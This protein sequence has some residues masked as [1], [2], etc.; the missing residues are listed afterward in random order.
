M[1]IGTPSRPLPAL[2]AAAAALLLAVPAAA[3]SGSYGYF[4]VIEGSA[5]VTQAGSGD[6]A[7]AELNQPVL[8]GDRLW[9]HRSGRL[10]AVLSDGNLLRVDG[11]SELLFERLADSPESDDGQ[12]VLRLLQGNVQLVVRR[13]GRELPR[14][15]T[16]NATV[17]LQDEGV[18]RI[19][20]D[21]E[22]WTEVVV[23]DGYAEVVTERGS[24]VVRTD[25][26]AWVEGVRLPD[27]DV[28]AAGSSDALER[29]ARR[30]DDEVEGD[31]YASYV[32]EDLRYQARPLSRYG[33][34]I[35]FNATWVWQPRVAHGWRPYHYGRW[36]YTPAGYFWVTSEPWGW[37]P[38]H[39]GTW[40]YVG[41]H[42]WVWYPGRTFAPAW[43]YW[44]WG[45]NYVGWCPIGY[46]TH[47]YSGWYRNHGFRR[48]VYGWAGGG[49][50]PWNDWSFVPYGHF[51][52]R[53][54]HRHARAGRDLRDTRP[55][56]PGRG[57]LT[58]DTRSLTPDRLGDPRGV[59]EV[60]RRRDVTPRGGDL[61]DV[62]AFVERRDEL[63]PE[64]RRTVITDRRDVPEGSPLRPSVI[65]DR[66][67]G[68]ARGGPEAP[69]VA[70]RDD[71]E[72]GE[73]DA[74]RVVP[75]RPDRPATDAGGETWRVR[76][77]DRSGTGER[78][79]GEGPRV[80]PSRPSRPESEDDGPRA[81]PS[82][83]S[84][85]ESDGGGNESWRIRG[86]D[87]G[88]RGRSESPRV[89]PTDRRPPAED[90]SL[91]YTAPPRR[92]GGSRPSVRSYAMP[93]RPAPSA[94]PPSVRPSRPP[95]SSPPSG[96]SGSYS[97]PPRQ[98]APRAS[99]PPSN[100]GGSRSVAPRSRGSDSPPSRSGGREA[101]GRSRGDGS[102]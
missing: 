71:G 53:D 45:P 85:P 22:G 33:S 5:T 30:L 93:Q 80:V 76:G 98:S 2:W 100:N 47:W 34:W 96:R 36:A 48:G 77:R 15:D 57:I 13:G 12:T 89:E 65:I 84:P 49:W 40:D 79:D 10:E 95:A 3:E 1:R 54:L 74:P 55:D 20:T 32:D 58:T 50:D 60:L 19:A 87:D 41:R 68:P 102:R 64:V 73:S 21:A 88:E 70:G 6:R 86:R 29:W 42:G 35:N 91:R 18:Y 14:I 90:R 62:T 44:H 81:V 11:G 25:E 31:R 17:Y 63:P 82:R 16:P 83:P 23:R 56:G 52:N 4:R 38:Y 66:R 59:Q 7:A 61:P 101:R 78:G 27:V 26:Q 97:P 37:V 94:P 69:R 43:V 51:R 72:R 24:A 67:A 39:Y 99:S 8:A 75:S 46:Y 92:D 9:V 28:Q